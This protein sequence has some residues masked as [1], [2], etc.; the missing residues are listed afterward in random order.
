M[1]RIILILLV[2]CLFVGVIGTFGQTCTPIQLAETNKYNDLG[3]PFYD[4]WV[5]G[6]KYEKHGTVNLSAANSF[7][8]DVVFHGYVNV[9][10][11][12]NGCTQSWN[13]SGDTY[14]LGL[15][16]LTLG[17]F[18]DD[19]PQQGFVE[20]IYCGPVA[21]CVFSNDTNIYTLNVV[22]GHS[23][24]LWGYVTI[25]TTVGETAWYSDYVTINVQ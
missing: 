8:T 15:Y 16:D 5:N 1:T 25:S 6:L 21:S 23:Y 10:A 2:L 7:N 4:F 13:I 20:N 24:H 18:V 9:K 14:Y 12:F 22:P 17:R 3:G 11:G 19:T